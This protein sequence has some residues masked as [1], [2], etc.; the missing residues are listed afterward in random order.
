M[1]RSLDSYIQTKCWYKEKQ[2]L[3]Y[4]AIVLD[5]NVAVL[6]AVFWTSLAMLCVKPNDQ[7][8]ML[9]DIGRWM[10]Q[11][12]TSLLNPENHLEING[13][14]ASVGGYD[15]WLQ[16]NLID[17]LNKLLIR[18]WSHHACTYIDER[19]IGFVDG[20]F[21]VSSSFGTMPKPWQPIESFLRW[22]LDGLISRHKRS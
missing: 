9:Y 12:L 4:F 5:C 3:F 2:I 21:T 8:Q 1:N 16:I 10:R 15:W 6:D 11:E 22:H 17:R 19:C 13:W 20:Q 7:K 18:V 14:S